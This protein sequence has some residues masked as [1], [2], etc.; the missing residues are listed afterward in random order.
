[1]RS[2]RVVNGRGLWGRYFNYWD[3]SIVSI[4]RCGYLVDGGSS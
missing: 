2:G 4:L 1:M 3:C